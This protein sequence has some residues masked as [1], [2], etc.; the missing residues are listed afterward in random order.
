ME[1]SKVSDKGS[2]KETVRTSSV[3]ELESFLNGD[4]TMLDD[5]E[6]PAEKETEDILLEIE[7]LLESWD[8]C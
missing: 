5:V 8:L 1:T 3:D 4:V 7:Q 2:V 6:S